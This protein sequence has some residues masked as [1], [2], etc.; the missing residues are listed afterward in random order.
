[1]QQMECHARMKGHAYRHRIFVENHV[2][3]VN[4]S[5]G[6]LTLWT[7]PEEGHGAG[8]TLQNV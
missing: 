5:D 8:N 1:M 3:R 2:G 4:V 7:R 6:T